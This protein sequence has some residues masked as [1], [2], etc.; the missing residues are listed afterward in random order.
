M[1]ENNVFTILPL[2]KKK[3]HRLTFDGRIVSAIGPLG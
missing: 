2:K 3:T 1:D